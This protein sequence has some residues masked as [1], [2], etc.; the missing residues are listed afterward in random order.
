[1]LA[2]RLRRW[3]SIKPTLVQ[4]LVFCRNRPTFAP[5][6]DNPALNRPLVNVSCS[7]GIEFIERDD[8]PFP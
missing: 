6:G 2:R 5:D 8:V 1:M 4:R 3:P 7:L